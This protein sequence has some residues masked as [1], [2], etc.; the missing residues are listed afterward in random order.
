MS[1]SI[2]QIIS[3]FRIYGLLFLALTFTLSSCKKAPPAQTTTPIASATIDVYDPM[4]PDYTNSGAKYWL[5]PTIELLPESKKAPILLYFDEAYPIADLGA[6]KLKSN[7]LEGLY[8][9]L[10]PALKARMPIEQYQASINGLIS[11]SGTIVSLEYRNQVM[12]Y[13]ADTLK[14]DIDFTQA[15]FHTFYAVTTTK[16]KGKGLFLDISVYDINGQLGIF[17]IQFT[18]YPNNVPN[19]LEYPNATVAPPE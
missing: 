12:E 2:F 14:G 5:R 15:A 10:S 13:G 3:R 18:G 7:D 4:L 9:M 16:Y 1:K 19:W 11:Q 17:S 8:T 6:Q